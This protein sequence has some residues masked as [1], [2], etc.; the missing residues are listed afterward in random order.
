[1]DRTI[2]H[3]Q[4]SGI[5]QDYTAYSEKR[6]WTGL[7]SIL[8]Q[9]VLDRTIQHILRQAVLDRTIQHTQ[10]SGI[11]QDYTAYS[12]KRYWTG[13]HSILRQAVL[14]RTTQHTQTS[15][16]GQ[17]Y[18]AYTHTSGI[19]QDYTAYT[20]TSGIGQ[21]YTA[22]S[23][24]RYWTGLYSI[25]RQ[26]VLE[27]LMQAGENGEHPYRQMG[28]EGGAAGLPTDGTPVYIPVVVDVAV[29]VVVTFLQPSGGVGCGETLLHHCDSHR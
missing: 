16:I 20:Q 10:T 22:Y 19:G 6:Y 18:T 14:D 11:G 15:G 17:D 9:A 13:L 12:D 25:L 3:T 29:V 28:G 2:Q 24:K 1:M 8:R 26:A 7:Y 5:G 23:D 4:T 21:D 27:G